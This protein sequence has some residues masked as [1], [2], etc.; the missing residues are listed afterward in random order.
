M[1]KI[2]SLILLLSLHMHVHIFSQIKSFEYTGSSQTYVVPDGVYSLKFDVYGAS[3][4]W[5]DYSGTR[6]DKYEPG[7]GG[8][9]Q[10]VLSVRP[11]QTI[12]IYV[13]GRGE[14][15]LSGTGGKGG[16][17]GG[18]DGNTSGVY[19][20]GGGGGATDIRI[21]GT[22]LNHRLLVAGGGGGAA[23]NYPDG[24]DD[25]G[26]GGDL[27]GG[28]GFSN[29]KQEDESRGRGGSQNEGGL[30]GQWPSY[31]RAT[32]GTFG[33]GGSG[34]A[35]TCGTGGGGGYYGGGGGCWSGGGGGSSYTHRDAKQVKHE[36]GVHSGNGKVIITIGNNF[37][38]EEDCTK[39]LI[40]VNGNT[41][42]C[43]GEY[44]SL[45][46]ISNYRA[47][48]SWDHQILN[49]VS[50][51]PPVG[52]TTYT[53]TSDD[54]RECANSI[55]ITVIPGTIKATTTN[56]IICEGESTT[57]IGYGAD[58]YVWDKGVQ[59]DVPFNPPVGVNNYTV[60]AVSD[61]PTRQCGNS[62]SVFVVVNKVDAVAQ[63]SEGNYMK[64]AGI[65]ITP[66]GGTYPYRF[67]W[68]KDGNEFAKSEDVFNLASGN[69]EVMIVDAI[70]CSV[71]K[72][73]QIGSVLYQPQTNNLTAQLSSDQLYL[74]VKYNGIFEYKI[75]NESGEIMITGTVQNE[76]NIDVSTLPSGA[77]RICSVHNYTSDNVNFIKW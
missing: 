61:D 4:G 2:S 10:A 75:L 63:V 1:N 32:D 35:G 20:G 27:I 74:N 22:T 51:S 12:F 18:G 15:A 45:N 41:T 33:I 53:V 54:R 25:G 39:P 42:L 69:Y 50:F 73:F 3:G 57:L 70:G 76:G 6:Y 38:Q 37:T 34:P 59:N 58:Q 14:D 65:D 40:Y 30:G 28:D 77:Y 8:H 56:G 36:Q 62:A 9:V 64:P 67:V 21:D 44:L 49:N 5:N 13:G 16:Y 47:S 11:G 23:Y 48:L 55:T 66:T 71:K 68:T 7:N 43:E 19:S 31:E 60:H 72:S 29:F 24:G 17:N 46:A 26:H 52:T